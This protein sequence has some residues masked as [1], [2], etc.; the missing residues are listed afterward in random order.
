MLV[1]FTISLAVLLGCC[2]MAIDVGRM[3]LRTTQLQAAAD[4]GALT[5]AAEVQRG[6]AAT[7][8]TLVQNE[9]SAFLAQANLPAATATSQY[10]AA[11]GPYTPD[12]SAMQV[13]VT[14]TL[15]LYF[16]A[17]V[18]QTSRVLTARA[19]AMVPPCVYFQS[20]TIPPIPTVR[21]ASTGFR[22]ACPVYIAGNMYNDYFSTQGNSQ[23]K[24]TGTAA[25]SAGGGGG[26][27]HLPI[28]NAPVLPD[29]LAYITAPPSPTALT[30]DHVGVVSVLVTTTL[31]PG[32][33]CGGITVVAATLTL[34]P[35]LYVITGPVTIS[36]GSVVNGSGVTIYLTKGAGFS[37]G[38][39]NLLASTWN[40]NAATDSSVPGTI[41]GI[42]LFGD[43]Y[44]VGGPNDFNVNNATWAGDGIIYY[45]NTGLVIQG[46]SMNTG[47][48]YFGIVASG[49]YEYASSVKP[50]SDYSTLP[51]GNPF[52]IAASLLQ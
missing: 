46:S 18:G 21:L 37:Y 28:F 14:Q 13:T 38:T 34:Q 11:T 26:N 24:L 22:A 33:Y 39:F 15:P 25:Q 43:R 47:G 41:P 5:A 52:H 12:Y 2:G 3:E 1:Y 9:V 6:N 42:I 44:W 32:R 10:T 20:A 17:L 16:M 19:V 48:H 4:D 7:Y 23:L 8:A 27:I 36:A 35:G 31:T 50:A 45:T 30:C 29:P 40:V 51:G 49:I